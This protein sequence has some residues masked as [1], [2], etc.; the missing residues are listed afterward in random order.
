MTA[1]ISGALVALVFLL[2]S[3]ASAGGESAA[4]GSVDEAR[5]ALARWIETQQIISKE[6]RD[7]QQGKEI[8]QSR[9]GQVR[10]ELEATRGRLTELEAQGAE[11]RGKREAVEGDTEALDASLVTL[12][13]KVG[14]LEGRLRGLRPRLPDPLQ[15][16]LAPL[17]DRMPAEPANTKISLA[18]RL[19]NVV[20]ILNEVNKS[21]GEITLVTEVRTLSDGKPSEVRTVY[22]GLAQA[23]FVSPSGKA[24][25][26][27]PGTGGWVWESADDLGPSVTEVVEILQNK[28]KPKFVPL[29]IKVS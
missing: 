17:F 16:K 15:Q 8:L 20:G 26:G 4:P 7:W 28:A 12:R 14:A 19:Q 27:R 29:R 3:A 6:K 22:V 18:E 9:I 25:I 1:R 10:A 2:G 5:S 11:V 21:N 24:G 13:E 23:F